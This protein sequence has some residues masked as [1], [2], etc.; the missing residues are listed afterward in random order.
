MLAAAFSFLERRAGMNSPRI[1]TDRD[2]LRE[3]YDRY[4]D[5]FA[6]YERGD[7]NRESVNYVSI[8][9]E[10]IAKVFDVDS[11]F[12]FGQLYY[13]LDRKYGY[14]RD[15]NAL[16]PLFTPVLG[17]ERNCVNF[18]FLAATLADLDRQ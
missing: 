5:K 4:Y 6:A 8:D 10:A 2:L 16:V 1:P 18:P 7:H 14:K 12:I 13:H 15:N 17:Q 11:N 9:L 3:I